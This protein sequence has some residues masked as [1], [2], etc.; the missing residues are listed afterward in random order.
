M[1]YPAISTVNGTV[2]Y[3]DTT[4]F[5][6]WLLLSLTFP[7]GY[8]TATIGNQLVPQ[9]IGN[10][11]QVRIQNGVY[12]P[13]THVYQSASIQP[14]D[15]QYTPKWYTNDMQL[16]ATGSPVTVSATPLTLNQSSLVKP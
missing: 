10:L 2:T 1:A 11:V 15:T 5:D 16:L 9:K 13:A 6:G 4:P 12:D 3:S 8:T 14:P 7:A